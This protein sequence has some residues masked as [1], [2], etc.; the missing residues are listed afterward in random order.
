MTNYEY[1]IFIMAFLATIVF[2]F[3][4]LYLYYTNKYFTNQSFKG[5]KK[6][7]E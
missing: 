7:K 5:G 3:N 2:L 1:I 4:V 6:I